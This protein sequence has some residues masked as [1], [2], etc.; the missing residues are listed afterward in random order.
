MMGK[1]YTDFWLSPV[2]LQ[3]N[4]TVCVKG[5]LEGID[6]SW[7]V[8]DSFNKHLWHDCSEPETVPAEK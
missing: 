4:K 1:S 7:K 8:S 5:P 2:R 3:N 6:A